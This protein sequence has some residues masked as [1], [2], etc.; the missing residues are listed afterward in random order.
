M[1]LNQNVLLGYNDYTHSGTIFSSDNAGAAGYPIANVLNVDLFTPFIATNNLP[2]GFT[3]DIGSVKPIDI[4]AFLKHN[5]V[6]Q[7]FVRVTIADDIGM[8]YDSGM[9]P[10]TPFLADFGALPWGQFTWGQTTSQIQLLNYN[11]HTFIPLPQ[12]VF[13]RYISFTINCPSNPSPILVSR[14]WASVGYQ[15]TFN[16]DYGSGVIPIDE[17]IVFKA[18]SGTRHYGQRVQRR[19]LS[20]NFSSLPMREMMYNIVGGLMLNGGVS[21]PVVCMLMPLDTTMMG[22]QSVYGNIQAMQEIDHVSFGQAQNKSPIVIEE[23]V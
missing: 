20:L 13:G 23:Q 17:T 18:F 3:V 19:A 15:P 22:I 12:T 1:I 21:D 6:T 4:V 10:V 7:G 9:V 5:I 11:Q 2:Q 8:Q 14:V 16:A